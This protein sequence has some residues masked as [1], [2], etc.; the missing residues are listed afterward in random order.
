MY[1]V[2]VHPHVYD[3]LEHS[4]TWYEESAA[5]L[6]KEFLIEIDRAIEKVQESPW[7]WPSLYE[8]HNV[9]RYLVAICTCDVIRTIGER[10]CFTG[11]AVTK[12]GQ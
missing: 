5:N 6:G 12:G 10:E 11:K 4:R 7:I 3:E 8:D 2:D 9:K 1:K